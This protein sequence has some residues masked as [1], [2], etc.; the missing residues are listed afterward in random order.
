M[1]DD[2]PKEPTSS[3]LI[4]SLMPRKEWA[5]DLCDSVMRQPTCGF[6]IAGYG[7]VNLDHDDVVAR[8]KRIL[9]GVDVPGEVEHR[10]CSILRMQVMDR[11]C[12][13]GRDMEMERFRGD[14]MCVIA[15]SQALSEE[16][17]QPQESPSTN[18]SKGGAGRDTWIERPQGRYADHGVR[19][20]HRRKAANSAFLPIFYYNSMHM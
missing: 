20:D 11:I 7:H 8:L 1:I 19:E 18:S 10:H 15:R 9:G 3:V 14:F 5:Q 6:I 12:Y 13:Q 4:K 2:P 17:Q 16:A